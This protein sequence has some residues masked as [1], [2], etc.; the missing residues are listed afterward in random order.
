MIIGSNN[1][2]IWT[3]PLIQ[4]IVAAKSW[5]NAARKPIS[6][7]YFPSNE[8]QIH[9]LFGGSLLWWYESGLE[10]GEVRSCFW[11]EMEMTFST[12]QPKLATSSLFQASSIPKTEPIS[13]IV[14]PTKAVHPGLFCAFVKWELQNGRKTAKP[15]MTQT[16]LPRVNA[17]TI[18]QEDCPSKGEELTRWRTTATHQLTFQYSRCVILATPAQKERKGREG[19]LY[20]FLRW[21]RDD[22]KCVLPS[23]A[24]SLACVGWKKS[25]R[26][27]RAHSLTMDGCKARFHRKTS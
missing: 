23:S 15:F 10:C 21:R 2:L 8:N 4:N 17:C 26:A 11:L 1:S 13:K 14:A 25:P 27:F 22:Q 18:Y 9:L 16:I 5:K 24:D 3:N 12:L 6:R 7:K 20:K 19:F